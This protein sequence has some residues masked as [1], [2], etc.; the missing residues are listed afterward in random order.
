MAAVAAV[1]ET[2]LIQSEQVAVDIQVVEMVRTPPTQTVVPAV[3]EVL[4]TLGPIK[5]APQALTQVMVM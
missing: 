5:Q 4:I 1:M 2:P 3:V